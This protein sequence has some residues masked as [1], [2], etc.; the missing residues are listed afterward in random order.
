MLR[1]LCYFTG[2]QTSFTFNLFENKAASTCDLSK[3]GCICQQMIPQ[4]IN[5]GSRDN[6]A[7]FY[8]TDPTIIGGVNP[9]WTATLSEIQQR[10]NWCVCLELSKLS[11]RRRQLFFH[12][13]RNNH[14][15]RSS[16]PPLLYSPCKRMWCSQRNEEASHKYPFD[17]VFVLLS[18]IA[19]VT[20]DH[21]LTTAMQLASRYF[22][23]AIFLWGGLQQSTQR[24]DWT[25]LNCDMSGRPHSNLMLCDPTNLLFLFWSRK[26]NSRLA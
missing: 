21:Y 7:Q 9:L 23:E 11:E 3:R 18:R 20:G 10:S 13:G 22:R 15:R 1:C 19:Q 24:L 4:N 16:L 6:I 5:P 17:L 12:H 25:R 14:D 2:F 8:G 26:S